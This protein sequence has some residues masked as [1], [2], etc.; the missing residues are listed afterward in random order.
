MGRN[1][2]R[3]A[4]RV[5]C[6]WNNSVAKAYDRKRLGVV[7]GYCIWALESTLIS[8]L[9]LS[10][11]EIENLLGLLEKRHIN[12]TQTQYGVGESKV[13]ATGSRNKVR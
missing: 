9:S 6:Y 11:I 7:K 3:K 10:S 1:N 8:S 5:I 4:K 13:C 12:L 2:F